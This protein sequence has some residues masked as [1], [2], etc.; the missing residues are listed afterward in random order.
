MAA[1]ISSIKDLI[2][3]IFEVIGSIFKTAFNA[4]EGI[5][6]LA[7]NTVMSVVNMFLDLITGS[8]KAM[9]SVGE[10][11]LGNFFAILIVAVGIFGFIAYQNRQGN[12]IKVGNKKLN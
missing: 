8:L 5:L 2:A 9:G 12:S 11:I 1:I 6:R 7:V 3:S 10:F 4:V